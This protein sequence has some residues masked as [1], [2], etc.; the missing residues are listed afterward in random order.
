V[1]I[2]DLVH[3]WLLTGNPTADGKITSYEK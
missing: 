1:K 3:G 2:G